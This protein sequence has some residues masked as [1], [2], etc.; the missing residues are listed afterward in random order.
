[1]P[2]LVMAVS[3]KKAAGAN[4]RSA[5]RGDRPIGVPHCRR[6]IC[7]ERQLVA[8]AQASRRRRERGDTAG[9]EA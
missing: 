2:L 3:M 4:P 5:K 8:D 9:P 1:M 6:S 7:G